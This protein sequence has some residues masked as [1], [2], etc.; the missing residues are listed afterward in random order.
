MTIGTSSG[1]RDSDFNSSLG[2]MEGSLEWW[3]LECGMR[4][5]SPKVA[6]DADAAIIMGIEYNRWQKRVRE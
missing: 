5:V 4:G 3:S 1:E 6:D 2:P